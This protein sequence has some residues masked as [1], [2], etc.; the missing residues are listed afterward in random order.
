MNKREIIL[1][2]TSLLDVVM[3]ILFFFIL[4]SNFE[5]KEMQAALVDQETELQA[6]YDQLNAD[7]EN[8]LADADEAYKKASEYLENS[9]QVNDRAAE[10]VIGINDFVNGN[11]LKIKLEMRTKEEGWELEI[12][13][14]NEKLQSIPHSVITKQDG[15][16]ETD[17]EKMTK[18][19]L[20]LLSET[21]YTS[22]DTIL[23]EF[24]YDAKE[25]GTASAYKVSHKL[26]EQ[27]KKEYK[28]FF[29]SEI[30]LSIFEEE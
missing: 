18:Q 25:G 11:R 26:F 12:Y 22:E 14:N 27:V 20:E 21:G 28:H 6:K 2:F 24:V 13:C 15:E 19:M 17:T 30:D 16:K 29:F 10:N 7:M 4:F 23:C 3:I 5:T 1:D 9:R 8:K